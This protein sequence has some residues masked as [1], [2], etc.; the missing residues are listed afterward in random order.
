MQATSRD[1]IAVIS[2]KKS[3]LKTYILKLIEKLSPYLFCDFFLSIADM[4]E[5]QNKN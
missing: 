3:F 5:A 4:K 1:A 2:R